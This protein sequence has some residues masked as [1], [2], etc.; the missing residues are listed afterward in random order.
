[1]PIS[2][3]LYTCAHFV[4]WKMNPAPQLGSLHFCFLPGDECRD[5]YQHESGMREHA[6]PIQEALVRQ[7]SLVH[8]MCSHRGSAKSTRHFHKYSVTLQCIGFKSLFKLNTFFTSQVCGC[9]L[10]PFLPVK[11]N[12]SF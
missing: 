9:I 2:L 12:V 6:Q 1:M 7:D 3:Q 8:T 10:S 11:K 4:A 5:G